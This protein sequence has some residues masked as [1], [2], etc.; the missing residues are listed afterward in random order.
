MRPNHP[1]IQFLSNCALNSADAI[2]LLDPKKYNTS[3]YTHLKRGLR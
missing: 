3:K 1:Y 2:V